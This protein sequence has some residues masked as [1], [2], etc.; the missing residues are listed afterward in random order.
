MKMRMGRR[1]KTIA[2]PRWL[3]RFVAGGGNPSQRGSEN[4]KV[5]STK[6]KLNGPSQTLLKYPIKGGQLNITFPIFQP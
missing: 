4:Q 1:M 5:I 6:N 3:D 2:M